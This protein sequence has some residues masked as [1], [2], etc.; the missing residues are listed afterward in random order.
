M[1]H[2]GAAAGGGQETYAARNVATAERA[3]DEKKSAYI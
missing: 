1:W 3:A 2:A